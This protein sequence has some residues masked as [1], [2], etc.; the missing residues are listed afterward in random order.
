MRDFNK[1]Q[2]EFIKS[3]YELLKNKNIEDLEDRFGKQI[4]QL[5]STDEIDRITYYLIKNAIEI[6]KMLDSYSEEAKDLIDELIK[7]GVDLSD[8]KKSKAVLNR[9]SSSN[10]KTLSSS[11]DSCSKP[12]YSG[13]SRSG[14]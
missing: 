11:R 7:I 6:G 13:S 5:Y 10:K 4:Q 2:I 12:S 14:C 1:E 9:I 3:Y 8:I